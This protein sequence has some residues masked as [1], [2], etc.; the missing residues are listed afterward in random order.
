[1]TTIAESLQLPA[2]AREATHN[3]AAHVAAE[4]WVDDCPDCI[5]DMR[6]EGF[7]TFAEVPVPPVNDPIDDC[8]VCA[9]ED[10]EARAA[11]RYAS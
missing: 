11:A 9:A 1:M 7:N 10:A 3:H 8:P 4:L 5:A 6:A 2:P